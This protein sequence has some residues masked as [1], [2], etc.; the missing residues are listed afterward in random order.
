MPVQCGGLIF[1]KL[2]N[3]DYQVT[4][5]ED[6]AD[7]TKVER[8]VTIPSATWATIVADAVGTPRQKLSARS[9]RHGGNE[10]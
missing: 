10:F 2:P 6:G 1:T 5:G 8:V 4:V 3:G 7:N 9:V